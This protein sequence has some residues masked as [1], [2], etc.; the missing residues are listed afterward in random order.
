MCLE[1]QCNLIAV[2]VSVLA[3]APP[4][5][6]IW[7]LVWKCCEQINRRRGHDYVM[8]IHWRG[9]LVEP[10]ERWFAER[11]RTSW[12]ASLAWKS[13]VGCRVDSVIGCGPASGPA[14]SR[15][16]LETPPCF[17]LPYAAQ[18]FQIEPLFASFPRWLTQL[19]CV[20]EGMGKAQ[21]DTFLSLEPMRSSHETNGGQMRISASKTTRAE[22]TKTPLLKHPFRRGHMRWFFRLCLFE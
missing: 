12:H 8:I 14:G 17:H 15:T 4:K 6:T 1:Y 11:C 10:G 5:D 2:I 7:L 18:V 13:S 20:E 9:I 19:A 3:R 16:E 22:S 21:N